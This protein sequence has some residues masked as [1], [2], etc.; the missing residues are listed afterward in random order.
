MAPEKLYVRALVRDFGRLVA[1]R[2]DPDLKLLVVGDGPCRPQVQA[3]AEKVNRRLGRADAVVM[4]GTVLGPELDALFA[5]CL[6]YVGMGTT[7][8]QAARAGKCSILA[9]DEQRHRTRSPAF[10]A[11]GQTSTGFRLPQMRL[12]SF[13]ERMEELLAHPERREALEAKAL[14]LCREM[15]EAE[16]V[17]HRWLEEYDRLIA[18]F[19]PRDEDVFQEDEWFFA[20]KRLKHRLLKTA[21]PA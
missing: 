12:T 18:T 19:D 2:G 4:K 16:A 11:D 1:A 17:M 21:L 6:F 14:T 9:T 8:L 15:F 13:H 5:G 10:F 20:L 3:L 7:V